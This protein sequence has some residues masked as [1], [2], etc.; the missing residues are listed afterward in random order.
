MMNA[1]G[2]GQTRLTNSPGGGVGADSCP[3]GAR[4]AFTRSV[5]GSKDIYTMKADGTDQRRLTNIPTEAGFP[6]W[7]PNGSQIVFHRFGAGL[8]AD[9]NEGIYVMNPDGTGQIKIATAPA[10]NGSYLSHP[11]W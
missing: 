2:T 1:N 4:I 10:V 9:P 3:G 11:S 5:N 8:P 6:E 7:S